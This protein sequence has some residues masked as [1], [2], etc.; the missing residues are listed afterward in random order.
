MSKRL[1][2]VLSCL[3]IAASLFAGEAAHSRRR[4]VGP[5]S[6]RLHYLVAYDS[7]LQGHWSITTW[8]D[9]DHLVAANP[10]A[11]AP[12]RTG[13]AIEV[14]F[15]ENG[16]GAFGLANMTDWNDVHYMYLNEFRTIEFDLFIEPDS[17]GMENLHFI[18]NDAGASS[19]PQLVSYI[20][21]WDRA[22]PENSAGRWIPVTID[23]SRIGATVPRFMRFLFYNAGSP[24]RPHFRMANVRLGWLEDSTPPAFTSVTATLNLTYDKLTL[25]FT[26]DKATTYR[27]EYGIGAYSKVINGD[28]A[29]L[30]PSHSA[31]LTGLSRGITYQYRI[32]AWQHQSDPTAAPTPGFFTGTYAMP[33]V[34]VT[35]PVI[36][37][38]AAMPPEIP[39]GESSKLT[40]AVADYEGLTIDQGVGTVA[41]IP[42]ATGVLVRP[43]ATTDYTITA[44]NALGSVTRT[45]KVTTHAVPAV[46]SFR[47][48]PAKINAG[49]TSTLTWDVAEFDAIS[50]D[51]GVGTVSAIPGATGVP[52]S[53]METTTYVLTASNAYG[54]ARQTV[55]VTVESTPANPVWVMGYYVG[56]Q[57]GLQPPDKVDYSAMTH[58]MVG[59]V[60][61]RK[62][63]TFE[64][65]FYIGDADGPAWAKEV[66]QRAHAAGTKA[67]L[68]VGGAG[69]VEGFQ[70]T[71]DPAI[72]AAFVSNLKA[73]VEECGFDGIDLDW[74]PLVPND[75]AAVSA[76]I[77]E[78]QAPGVLPRSPY[79][80]TLPV[81]WN[82][83][84][85]NDMANPF[86]GELAAHFDR[87]STMSYSMLWSGYGWQSWHSSALY[88]ETPSTPSSIDNTVRALHAAGVPDAKI[89][90]GIGFYGSSYENGTWNDGT[91]VH[92]DPPAIPAYVTEPHQSTETAAS[93]FG[94]NALSYSN[95]MRYVHSAIAYRWDDTARV[96]YLSFSRPALF[97][98][99]GYFSDMKTTYV[100]YENEQS[101]AEK[102]SYVRRNGLGGVIIWTVSQGYLG[103]WKSTGELDPLMKAVVAAFRQ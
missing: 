16:W 13:N 58:I 93:R 53:A 46:R 89:G 2:Q 45:V 56:Y 43:T 72:R 79:V 90:I 52:V 67:I 39:V 91:F 55:T 64:T 87:V 44:T 96:P 68:M 17:T 63:G 20:A 82:N 21:G 1:F 69:A 66:V 65:H 102:G 54:T 60:V 32:T 76:L 9:A 84:N 74:E 35:P 19:G 49:G 92:L 14:R 6:D 59:A 62:N 29:E 48:T 83:A 10:N 27:V 37:S 36:S 77:V 73:F 7:A 22:H 57:R 80:Y 34:P 11:A 38:F 24:S 15:S 5:R 3:L 31:Q 100:T 70:A 23:L 71:R 33:P 8:D 95:V 61:P 18:L 4:A 41:Q 40:W 28:P 42:G 97:A 99:P 50:I 51:H 25:A 12:G 86:Y 26:N 81:G 47:A 75:R 101:I 94:D 98:I 30:S 88:G 78:L 103:G 85:F